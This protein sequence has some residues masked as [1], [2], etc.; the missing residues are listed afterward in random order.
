MAR[1]PG[2]QDDAGQRSWRAVVFAGGGC[3][4]FW[5]AGF[6]SEAAPALGLAPRVAAATSAGAAFACAVFAGAL[7]SVVEDFSRRVAANPRNLYP[8]N[9]LR[10]GAVFPHEAIYRA[11][12][13]AN[14]DGERLERI[15]RGPELRV[16]LARPPAGVGARR[17]F[18]LALFAFL[19]ERRAHHHRV[20]AVWGRRLGFRTEVVVANACTSPEELAE[21]VL[22]ASCTPPVTPYYRRLGRPVLDGGL[23]DHIPVE[24]VAGEGPTLVLLTR[25]YPENA[26][27]RVPGRT[28][29]QPSETL[30]VQRWDYTSPQLVRATFELGRRDGAAFAAAHGRRVAA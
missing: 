12:L 24:A 18:A 19:V 3:R 29:V 14:L 30:P 20:H 5:Q 27:P 23:V 16:V 11:T 15:R 8:W 1:S 7:E 2:A 25:R 28:Y 10:G 17:A 21:L 13:L 9:A 22:H 6:W 26:L 4:C